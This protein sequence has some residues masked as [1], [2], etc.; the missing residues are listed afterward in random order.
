MVWFK[1]S[2]GFVVKNIKALSRS[3]YVES[4]ANCDAFYL[5]AAVGCGVREVRGEELSKKT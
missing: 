1:N 5:K 2:E 4:D 3:R